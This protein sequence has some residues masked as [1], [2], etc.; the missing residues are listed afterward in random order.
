MTRSVATG[1]RDVLVV[2][3][4]STWIEGTVVDPD[5]QPVPHA[6]VYGYDFRGV[7]LGTTLADEHGHFRYMVAVETTTDFKAGWT[8]TEA[9]GGTTLRTQ[10]SRDSRITF[11]SNAN[12]YTFDKTGRVT[13]GAPAQWQIL[14]TGG[15]PQDYQKRCIKLDPSGRPRT[16]DGVCS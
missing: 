11:T 6:I 16:S 9:A 1:T 10:S 2:I 15:T 14:P 8:I 3:P 5:S 12:V 7:A 13:V 4:R